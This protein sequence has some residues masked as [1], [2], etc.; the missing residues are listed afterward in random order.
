MLSSSWSRW[1]RC[2]RP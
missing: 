1:C 2:W